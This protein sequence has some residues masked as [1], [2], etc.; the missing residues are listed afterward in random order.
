MFW[1]I[2]GSFWVILGYSGFIL[3][4]SSQAHGHLQGEDSEQLLKIFF[5]SKMD[6]ICLEVL[7]IVQCTIQ[8]RAWLRLNHIIWFLGQSNLL[9]MFYFEAAIVKIKG[10][11]MM[12]FYRVSLKECV[13]DGTDGWGKSRGP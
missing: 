10:I 7:L 11:R 4:Y 9:T 12:A 3:G 6:W 2:L 13:Q 5:T 8:Q 1:V